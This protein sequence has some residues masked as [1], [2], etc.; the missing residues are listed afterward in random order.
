MKT[1]CGR[2]SGCIIRL[3]WI[4]PQLYHIYLDESNMIAKKLNKKRLE[5]TVDYFFR[6]LMYMKMCNHLVE[7]DEKC[8]RRLAGR[9]CRGGW[10]K[11]NNHSK[12]RCAAF[13]QQQQQTTST[14]K[15]QRR[16]Y[17]VKCNV[18]FI[19]YCDCFLELLRSQYSA[20]ANPD[21]FR[22]DLISLSV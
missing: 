6:D 2:I 22:Q 8:C 5:Q 15:Q 13:K 14:A 18:T 20:A 16:N 9:S 10:A 17:S 21:T 1:K 3:S 11:E 7:G 19:I 12:R 4:I